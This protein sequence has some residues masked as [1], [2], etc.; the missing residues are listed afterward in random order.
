MRKKFLSVF[1][2]SSVIVAAAIAVGAQAP[3]QGRNTITG[4]VFDDSRRPA[5][6][7]FVELR[8]DF[9]STVARTR[10]NGSGMYQFTSL[11]QGTYQIKIVNTTTNYEE[12]TKSVSLI[13]LSVVQGAGMASEH[14]DFHLKL[15]A[16][17]GSPSQK[18]APPEVIFA[19]AVPAPAKALYEAGLQDLAAK[20]DADGLRKVKES[21]ELFPDYYDALDKLGTDYV[22]RGHYEAAFVLFTKAVSVNPR[23][24]SS[25]FGLGLAQYRLKMVDKAIATFE[26]ASEINKN[27]ANSHLW[28]GIALHAAKKLPEALATLLKAGELTGNT[29]A[30]VYF[31]LAKVYT[32]QKKYAM[33]ADSLEL[34]LKYRPDAQNTS[35]IRE[36]VASLRKK[37]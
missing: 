20:K 8:N 2:L 30:E 7:I 22:L 11:P 24:F 17:Q 12:Q 5:R 25:T 37:A 26:K 6:D 4:F 32:D 23:S 9:G 29:S 3:G 14:V 16:A 10:V 18:Q 33:A 27:S 31:Q 36:L 13:P 34:F 15:R 1:V 21:I 19:Q 35:Q 28:H